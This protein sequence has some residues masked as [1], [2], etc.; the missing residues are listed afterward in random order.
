MK[1]PTLSQ[2]IQAV[3]AEYILKSQQEALASMLTKL[4]VKAVQREPVARR[5]RRARADIAA[6]ESN[7][8]NVVK[9][10][11][12]ES[13]T[14]FAQKLGVESKILSVPLA[15]LRKAGHIRSVGSRWATRYYPVKNYAGKSEGTSSS[16]T[17]AVQQSVKN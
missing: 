7:L 13:A 5:Q 6:T 11:P 8:A 1:N 12:G 4:K 3:I 2:Q 9:E 14:F 17:N 10:H 15:K 16:L